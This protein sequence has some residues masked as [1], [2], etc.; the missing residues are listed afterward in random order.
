MSH[1]L[2]QGSAEFALSDDISQLNK[3][4]HSG[5]A[6]SY[7]VPKKLKF[8]IEKKMKTLVTLDPQQ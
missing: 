7:P 2:K 4:T 6:R 3:L 1:E 8:H 5:T